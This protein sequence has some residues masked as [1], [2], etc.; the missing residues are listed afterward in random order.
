MAPLASVML[1]MTK[2]PPPSPAPDASSPL[3]EPLLE[4][5]LEDALL[6]LPLLVELP[7]L[8]PLEEEPLDPEAPL[9]LLDAVPLELG[10]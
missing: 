4:P 2:P 1:E 9:P 10:A 3:L 6:V 8:D 7:E 5:P